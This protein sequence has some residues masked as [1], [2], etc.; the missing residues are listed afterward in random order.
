MEKKKLLILGAGEAQLQIIKAAQKLGIYTI[1]C[2]ARPQMEG[3][4][5]A[6]KYYSVDY[7]EKEAILEI[8]EKEG[9]SGVISNSE[10]A[11]I[12]VAW[13]AEKLRLPGNSVESVKTLLSKSEFRNLQ[14]VEGVYAP[15]HLVVNSEEELWYAVKEIGF[16]LVIKPVLSSGTRGTTVVENLDK[17]LIKN[18]YRLCANFSRNNLVSIE[19]YVPM[20]SLV[21]YDAEIFVCGDEI[22]WD[23]LYASYRTEDAPMLPVMECLPLDLPEYRISELKGSIE[24]LIHASG[25]KLGE[26]NAEAYF[27]P[28]GELFVIEINPRKGGNHIPDLVY[29]HSGIDFTALLCATSVGDVKSFV[30]AKEQIRKNSFV[31]MYVVFSE[32]EGTFEGIYIN[33]VIRPYVRWIQNVAKMGEYISKKKNAGDALAFVRMTFESL[34]QQKMFISDISSYIKPVLK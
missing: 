3:A 24:K 9:I 21:A 34:E 26:F 32:I 8:A 33:D 29:E 11:M 14:Q 31:T 5:I 19:E 25:I 28:T 18:S 23:G 22:L 13:L 1:V 6:D 20:S 2:D 17:V 16:P 10:P 15:K 12:N 4:K 27:T 30:K 7:M